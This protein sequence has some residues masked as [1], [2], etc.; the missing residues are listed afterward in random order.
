[1]A[2]NARQD[3]PGWG[4]A[5]AAAMLLLALLFPMGLMIFDPDPH[6]RAR[7][8]T[9]CRDRHLFL[10]RLDLEPRITA[11]LEERTGVSRRAADAETADCIDWLSRRRGSQ[12]PRPADP[13][14]APGILTDRVRQ[15]TGCLTKAG[16][17]VGHPA[18]GGQPRRLGAGSGTDGRPVHADPVYSLSASRDRIHRHRRGHLAGL[19]E[20]QQ[21]AA[22][23][24]EPGWVLDQFDQRDGGLADR[25]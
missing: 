7:L 17:T 21:G 15:L 23:G 5:G 11:P 14:A 13:D 24:E 18:H 9:V 2:T 20:Y 1:M 10:G 16:T 25:V 19:D 22:D 4:Y 3:S 12:S 6:V 8:G